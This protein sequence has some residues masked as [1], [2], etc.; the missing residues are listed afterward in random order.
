[1]AVLAISIAIPLGAQ[2][3]SA[4]KSG[5]HLFVLSGQSNMKHMN[6]GVSFTPAVEKAFGKDNV[7]VVKNAETGAPLLKWD[8]DYKWPEDKPIPQ[9]RKKP[10]KEEKRTGH[11]CAL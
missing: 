10:G 9:G 11:R 5:K 3:S 8:K 6:Q 4:N 1:M 7:I 2:E